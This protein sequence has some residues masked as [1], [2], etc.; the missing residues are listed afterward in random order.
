MSDGPS[1]QSCPSDAGPASG[2]L[3]GSLEGERQ[4]WAAWRAPSRWTGA[5]CIGLGLTT[6]LSVGCAPRTLQDETARVLAIRPEAVRLGFRTD[7]TTSC[8]VLLRSGAETGGPAVETPRGT[9]H[10]VG[11]DGLTPCDTYT[12]RI[13][14]EGLAPF[15]HEIRTPTGAGPLRIAVLGDS[16]MRNANEPRRYRIEGLF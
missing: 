13:A 10:R 9:R 14:C 7:A 16:G 3:R 12:Y 5:V 15:E 11:F 2:K 4:T 8:Q 1:R 6:M